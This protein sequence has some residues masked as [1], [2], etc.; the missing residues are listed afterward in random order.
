V[1]AVISSLL[2]RSPCSSHSS[3]PPAGVSQSLCPPPAL[4]FAFVRS[5]QVLNYRPS[6]RAPLFALPT[7]QSRP[8]RRF[9]SF[10]VVSGGG[11][12]F[13]LWLALAIEKSMLGIHTFPANPLSPFSVTHGRGQCRL[14]A[15]HCGSVTTPTETNKQHVTKTFQTTTKQKTNTKHALLHTYTQTK[16][17]PNN[18]HHSISTTRPIKQNLPVHLFVASF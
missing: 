17:T 16:P 1:I 7:R 6:R 11:S 8:L 10:S 2:F 5:F 18:N 14:A 3:T 15:P 4:S 13:S 9:S 12:L